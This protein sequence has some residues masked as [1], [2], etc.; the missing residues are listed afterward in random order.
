MQPQQC[1]G[2]AVPNMY[3]VFVMGMHSGRLVPLTAHAAVA[4][5]FLVH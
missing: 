3:L 1:E 2:L 5:L 4:T